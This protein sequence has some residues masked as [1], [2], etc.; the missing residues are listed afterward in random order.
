M[1]TKDVII[2]G[3]GAQE[4]LEQLQASVEGQLKLIMND[5][6][7]VTATKIEGAEQTDAL[8]VLFHAANV[9][10]DYIVTSQTDTDIRIDLAEGTNYPFFEGGLP[11]E[12]VMSIME[13]FI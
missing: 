1:Q 12:E 5:K 4:A 2:K 13:K 6:G 11:I 3:S 10:K 9:D 8:N 7:K